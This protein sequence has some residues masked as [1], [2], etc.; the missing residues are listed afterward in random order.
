M[1]TT[2]HSRALLVS[3]LLL[4]ACSPVA[5]TPAR[6][7]VPPATSLTSTPLP[8]LVPGAP[9]GVLVIENMHITPDVLPAYVESF[10]LR[11]IGGRTG[12]T[13]ISIS[14][15]LQYAE[16]NRMAGPGCVMKDHIDAGATWSSAT[17]YTYCRE[18][19]SERPGFFS[20]TVSYRDDEG[21][22]GTVSGTW[23]E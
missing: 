9:T 20:V 11:E 12:A 1:M 13:I 8:P 17:L 4:S 23:K 3:V 5:P 15:D 14:V 16:S 19:A 18:W 6:E 22:A 7:P 21:H 10:T 2:H